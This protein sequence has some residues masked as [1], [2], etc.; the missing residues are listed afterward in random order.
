L[1]Y[2]GNGEGM[3]RENSKLNPVSIYAETKLKA[4]KE[5]AET[6]DNYLI[7]RTSLLIGFGL[8]HSRNNFH[9]MYNKLKAGESPKLF[10]GQYRTPFSLLDASEIISQLVKSDL[11]EIILNFGG[12]ERVSRVELGELLCKIAG[13]DKGLIEKIKIS[14]IPGF[15]AVKDVSLNTEKLRSF[16]FKQKPLEKAVEEILI[17]EK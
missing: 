14:D 7:L 16:G 8:N 5:I 12:S 6:F 3:L 9:V 10:S 11:K 1:V 15:P 13:F 4:E 2:E 17:N